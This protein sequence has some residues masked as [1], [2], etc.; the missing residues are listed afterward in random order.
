MLKLW[1]FLNI[2]LLLL[3]QLCYNIILILLIKCLV[4]RFVKSATM[5]PKPDAD[6]NV[7]KNRKP[8]F[9]PFLVIFISAR[10][11]EEIMSFFL[12]LSSACKSKTHS[13]R[14]PVNRHIS[15]SSL[16]LPLYF[17]LLSL[18]LSISI[19]FLSLLVVYTGVLV[20]F[21]EQS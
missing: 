7:W 12:T 2:I 11:R 8:L 15:S 16:T 13:L 1:F 6:K 18:S 4:N 21:N 10:S 3:I 19:F 9:T 20:Y 5:W 17:Y 14:S